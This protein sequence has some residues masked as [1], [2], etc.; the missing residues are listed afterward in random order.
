VANAVSGAGAPLLGRDVVK[1]PPVGR[2]QAPAQGCPCAPAERR[3][4]S[5]VDHLARHA[6]G[7]AGIELHAALVAHDLA[8]QVDEID[9]RHRAG[10]EIDDRFV[11]ILLPRTQITR[12]AED[13]SDGHAIE[14]DWPA[15]VDD[16][17]SDVHREHEASR[18]VGGLVINS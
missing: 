10:A 6:G 3:G 13:A 4:K 15:G 5:G 11:E 1:V 7:T 9:E 8:D 16:V 2:R 17:G 14:A 12:I 18:V